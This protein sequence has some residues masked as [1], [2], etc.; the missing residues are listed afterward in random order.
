MKVEKYLLLINV[1]FYT[2]LSLPSRTP[3][4]CKALVFLLTIVQTIINR[5]FSHH[6]VVNYVNMWLSTSLATY[7]NTIG[8]LLKHFCER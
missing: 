6:V 5:L 3:T 7:V 8:N 4:K 2:L 1:I